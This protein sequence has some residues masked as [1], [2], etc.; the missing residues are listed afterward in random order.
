MG[1]RFLARIRG[2]ALVFALA[3]SCLA[4]CGGREADVRPQPTVT[5]RLPLESVFGTYL[6]SMVTAKGVEAVVLQIHDITPVENGYSF[7]YTVNVRE[8]MEE[9]LGTLQVG[10]TT[11]RVCFDEDVC[12]WLL[13]EEGSVR[14]AADSGDLDAPSWSL[15]KS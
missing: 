10:E 14:I 3:A 5:P 11:T 12:G 6:G 7:R 9:G 2:R 8:Q 15:E 1:D 4:A 13:S